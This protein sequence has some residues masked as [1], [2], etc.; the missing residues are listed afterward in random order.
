[1]IRVVIHHFMARPI[2]GGGQPTLRDCESHRVSN[3]LTQRTRRNF[4]TGHHAILGMPRGT[5]APS[6]KLLYISHRKVVTGEEQQAVEQHAGMPGGQHKTIAIGPFWVGGIVPKMARPQDVR[7]RRR[8]QRRPRMSRVR[9]LDGV[10]RQRPDRVDA[11]LVDWLKRRTHGFSGLPPT[12]KRMNI[13][14][15]STTPP[16]PLLCV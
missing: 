6:A 13:C 14:N 16:Y 12:L 1:H 3:T 2:E 4:R 11:K 15:E 7:H 5:A 8:A 9:F 10:D